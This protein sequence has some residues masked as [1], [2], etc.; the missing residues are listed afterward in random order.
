MLALEVVPELSEVVEWDPPMEDPEV[1]LETVLPLRE[2][3]DPVAAMGAETL[4]DCV[5]SGNGNAS[6]KA[7]LDP[8]AGGVNPSNANC[9]AGGGLNLAVAGE[10]RTETKS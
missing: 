6:V 10:M 4:L 3:L 7:A 9:D 2:R 1:E 8:F 5:E